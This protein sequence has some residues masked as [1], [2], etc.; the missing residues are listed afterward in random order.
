M[1]EY[2]SHY[3]LKKPL[4]TDFYDIEDFNGNMDDVDAALFQ[5]ATLGEDGKIPAS[6]LP[7]MDYDPAGSAETV[8][9]NL[10]THI[11]D[12][13]NP[14]QVTA[15]Q[16]GAAPVSHAAADTSYG[17]GSNT[18]FG[19][20]KVTPGN[21]LAIAGGVVNMGAASGSAAGAVTTGEQTFAGDKTFTGQVNVE[22]PAPTVQAVRNMYAGT[23]DM[24]AGT[25]EL[26]TG[27]IY[28]MYE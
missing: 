16:A 9:G 2:T 28:L 1:A 14:H 10:D 12:Q 27:L 7:E 18:Q 4:T 20:V 23:S 11:A 26:T 24:E 13:N 3:H 17:A 15:A 6:Q 19:H 21:G 8:Q 5:K 22:N 25:T